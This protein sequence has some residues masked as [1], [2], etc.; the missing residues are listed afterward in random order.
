MKD[1][2]SIPF[3][4]SGIP[5]IE[6]FV[7]RKEELIRIKEAF[8]DRGSQRKV[9]LLC[10]LGGIGKTQ[11]AVAFLKEHRDIYPAI[12]WLNGKTEDTLKQSFAGI[13]KRLCNEYPSSALLRTTL[14]EKNIDRIVAVIKQ[15]LSIR[16][17]T[18]WILI[19][20]NVD[21]PK[22]PSISN[23][24]TYDIRLYF[25]EV[26][27]GSILITTRSSRLN[28]GKVVFVKKLLEIQE[29]ITI[30]AST[31]GRDNLDQGR[32]IILLVQ[33]LYY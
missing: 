32:Y 2:F 9:V 11:L 5:E 13:A 23:P 4:L 8:Q 14:E 20:D 33:R 3:S 28:I 12:F 10:G 16:G 31:S 15:W 21:N 18:Q 7:G 6:Q 17:N 27:Q 25:P 26:H 24:Q 19:F 22:L 1:D 30:L 29:C